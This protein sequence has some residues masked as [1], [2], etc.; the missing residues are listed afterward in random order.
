MAQDRDGAKLHVGDIVAIRYRIVGVDP[1][2]DFFNLM[3]EP[4]EPYPEGTNV[5]TLVNARQ[6]ELVEALGSSHTDIDIKSAIESKL[7]ESGPMPVVKDEEH[8]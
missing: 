1:H 7:N 3:I 8:G 5:P 2:P 4:L 6:A